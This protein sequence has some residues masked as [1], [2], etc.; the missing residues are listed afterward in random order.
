MA[1]AKRG[2]GKSRG[3]AGVVLLAIDVLMGLGHARP[4]PQQRRQEFAVGN[5][6][7]FCAHDLAG[8]LILLFVVQPRLL[9]G[10]PIDEPV[11][12]AREY[13]VQRGQQGILIRADVAGQKQLV[14]RH[15]P[16]VLV[17]QPRGVEWQ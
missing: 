16:I 15:R 2:M 13:G 12:L 14:V 6:L 7:H 4:G 9:E 1:E 17:P 5:H 10:Y 8:Q 3:D 11:V